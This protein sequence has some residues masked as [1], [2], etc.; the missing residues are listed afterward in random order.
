MKKIMII[1]GSGAG[2]S[3]LAKN[4]DTLLNIPVYHLDAYYWKPG[5]QSIERTEIKRLQQSFV[6]EDSWII[7]GNYSATMDI[8]LQAADTVIFLNYST[9]RRLFR[10]IKRRIQYNGKTR[11]DM[12]K[13]CP[14]KIDWEFLNWVIRFKK[15]KVPAIRECLAKTNHLEIL[16]FNSPKQTAKFLTKLAN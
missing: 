15:D 2:K 1:G 10:V 6:A 9:T 13:D 12:G 16:E 8:R 3:T 14:E 4:L 7:D 5:W 11:P